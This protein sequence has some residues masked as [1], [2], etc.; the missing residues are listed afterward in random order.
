MLLHGDFLQSLLI[1]PF[2]IIIAA[3]MLIAPIWIFVDV[4]ARKSTLLEFYRKTEAVLKKP[5][6]A[7]SL[8][9]FVVINWIWNITKGL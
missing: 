4:A 2:G 5:A 3:I 8:V 9:I 7:I 1:N 6:M